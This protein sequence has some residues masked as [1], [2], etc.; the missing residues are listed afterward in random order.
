MSISRDK[1]HR[2]ASGGVL[3]VEDASLMSKF[4][5]PN[6]HRCGTISICNT[7]RLKSTF[8]VPAADTVN[9]PTMNEENRYCELTHR[10]L[11]ELEIL[12]WTKN[13]R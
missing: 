5:Y 12:G 8:P 7:A 1:S 13:Q 11:T 10:L 2:R 6:H 4:Q 3:L 9:Q